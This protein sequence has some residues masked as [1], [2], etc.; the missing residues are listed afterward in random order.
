MAVAGELRD[1]GADVFFLGA[2][3]R[4]ES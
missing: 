4:I 3:G 1:S 2:R